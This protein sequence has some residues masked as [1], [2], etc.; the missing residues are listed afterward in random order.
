MWTVVGRRVTV[1]DL[2][3]RIAALGNRWDPF[4]FAFDVDGEDARPVRVTLGERFNRTLAT[5]GEMVTGP[6]LR[7]AAAGG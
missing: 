6:A 4:Q 2:R 7:R 5:L 3:F 1:H